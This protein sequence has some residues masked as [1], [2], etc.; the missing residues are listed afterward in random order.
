MS[1]K[2]KTFYKR[3]KVVCEPQLDAHGFE[4]DKKRTFRKSVDLGECTAVQIIEF[5]IGTK[6]LTGR[7]TVNLGVYSSAYTRLD[8]D[9]GEEPQSYFCLC[10]N[11][12]RLGY[13]RCPPRSIWD[14]LR[15]RKAEAQDYWWPQHESERNMD[16]TLNEVTRLIETR[17]L[18]WLDSHSSVDSLSRSYQLLEERRAH[19]TL[20]DK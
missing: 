20:P 18:A 16:A 17:G 14:R 1:S 4:F 9:P 10:D 7:F 3:M 6:G 8:G 13:F 2:L 12:Q 5:Q 15:G 19:H 11:V